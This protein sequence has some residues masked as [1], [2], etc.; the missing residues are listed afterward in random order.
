MKRPSPLLW[1][2]TRWRTRSAHPLQA[3]PLLFGA[4][5]L[6]GCAG[7]SSPMPATAQTLPVV[8]AASGEIAY[9]QSLPSD[10]RIG[11]EVSRDH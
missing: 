1:L 2:A 10:T 3:C 8:D 9:F 6:T 7:G 4:L 5:V 11:A